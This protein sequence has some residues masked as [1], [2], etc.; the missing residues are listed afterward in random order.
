M[1][2]GT[3]GGYVLVYDVRYNLVASQFRHNLNNPVLA[4]SQVYRPS[5]SKGS[6]TPGYALVSSGFSNYELS[7]LNLETGKLERYFRSS[8]TSENHL[9]QSDLTT[10]PEYIKETRFTDMNIKTLR[11]DT[12]AGLFTRALRNFN[13]HNSFQSLW[14]SQEEGWLRNVDT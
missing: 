5:H 4:L 11:R 13:S 8:E 14:Q 7:Q 12:N 6:P 1:T 9:S 10:L 3:L 2:L